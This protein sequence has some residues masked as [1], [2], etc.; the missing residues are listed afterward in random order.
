[1][2]AIYGF[3]KGKHYFQLSGLLPKLE[4]FGVY[5][6]SEVLRELRHILF[7]HGQPKD[8]EILPFS[9]SITAGRK[10]IFEEIK[11]KTFYTRH[12]DEYVYDPTRIGRFK[13]IWNMAEEV[14]NGKLI[15]LL[16]VGPRLIRNGSIP[17]DI[18]W[19]ISSYVLSCSEETSMKI[20]TEKNKIFFEEKY[21]NYLKLRETVAFISQN[22]NHVS[23]GFLELTAVTICYLVKTLDSGIEALSSKKVNAPLQKGV[24]KLYQYGTF[25][26]N[27]PEQL[28]EAYQNKLAFN[29]SSPRI[30]S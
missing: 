5:R 2:A 30:I 22:M 21:Y 25:F 14:H 8:E 29:S 12:G 23:G 28:Q 26:W 24:C 9:A 4:H 16:Q 17:A 3:A 6:C 13:L 19:K 15:W 10:L 7:D 11:P 18:F 1:V 20:F 27:K